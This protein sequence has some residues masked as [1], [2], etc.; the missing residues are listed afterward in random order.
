MHDEFSVICKGLVKKETN[1]E[2]FSGLK[3]ELSTGESGYVDGS[4]GLSGKVKIR[5]PGEFNFFTT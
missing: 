1:I 5:I 2:L 3:V 4:F